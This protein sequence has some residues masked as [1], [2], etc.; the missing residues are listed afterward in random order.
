MWNLWFPGS[1][2]N[3][4]WDAGLQ[5]GRGKG[6]RGSKSGASSPLGVKDTAALAPRQPWRAEG[7]ERAPVMARGAG[8]GFA[9]RESAGTTLGAGF[10][11][12]VQR[13]LLSALTFSTFSV[14][15]FSPS[16]NVVI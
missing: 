10:C 1:L 7:E 11:R 13:S 15:S 16:S 14:L 2:E 3:L 4:L 6:E 12:S 5:P 9:H 8:G